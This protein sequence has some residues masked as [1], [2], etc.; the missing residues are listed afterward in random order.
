MATVTLP[1]FHV[2]G[3]HAVVTFLMCVVLFGAAH[4]LAASKPESTL[5]QAWIGLGF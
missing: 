2:S 1:H 4:L 3:T 5:A